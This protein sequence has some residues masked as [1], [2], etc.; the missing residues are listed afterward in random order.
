MT[1]NISPNFKTLLDHAQ[2]ASKNAYSPYS[3]FTVGSCIRAENGKYYAGC[4][5]ENASY[6]LTL[7]AETVAIGNMVADNA[8]EIQE[9]IVIANSDDFCSP[10]GACRQRIRE[11][12]KPTTTITMCN[13]HCDSKT[14]TVAELL[15]ESFGPE[16]LL[17]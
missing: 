3:K 14:M 11:F 17:S 7:C 9:I 6:S 8:K 12:A 1:N 4:N 5:V 10:C 13:Q 16:H 2:K 15:P